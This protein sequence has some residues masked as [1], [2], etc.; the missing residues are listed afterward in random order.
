MD[1]DG[2]FEQVEPAVSLIH[3]GSAGVE[4]LAKIFGLEPV[5]VAA[6]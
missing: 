3:L 1:P 4:H 2:R 6:N 5:A